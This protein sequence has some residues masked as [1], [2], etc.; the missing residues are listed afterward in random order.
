MSHHAMCNSRALARSGL[1]GER[2]RALEVSTRCSACHA[3][4]VESKAPQKT[5]T[6]EGGHHAIELREAPSVEAADAEGEAPS[7]V[8]EMVR[9][10]RES[11]A[12]HEFSLHRAVSERVR[13]EAPRSL[14]PARKTSAG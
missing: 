12:R 6:L 14:R 11:Q 1:H 5:L 9:W 2:N 4:R 10:R 7:S 3:C 8:R 13:S